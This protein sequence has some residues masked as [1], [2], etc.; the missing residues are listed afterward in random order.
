MEGRAY[1]SLLNHKQLISKNVDFKKGRL[2]AREEAIICIKVVLNF[3]SKWKVEIDHV[4]SIKDSIVRGV[5]KDLPHRFIPPDSRHQRVYS[6]L[7]FHINSRRA[8]AI[9]TS[10]LTLFLIIIASALNS[11]ATTWIRSLIHLLFI[12]SEAIHIQVGSSSFCIQ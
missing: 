3:P 2:T 4:A 11:L 12:A 5:E 9:C 6:K 1:L 10:C 8:M 7:L